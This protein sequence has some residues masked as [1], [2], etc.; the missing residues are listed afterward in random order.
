MKVKIN[1]IL[2]NDRIRKDL[3][4]LTELAQDIKSNGLINPPVVTPGMEL[5]AGERRL[6]ALKLNGESEVDVLVMEIRDAEHMLNLEISENETRKDF[7][8]SERIE[9][10]R[11][12]ERIESLKALQRKKKHTQ[13][14]AEGETREIVAKAIGVS[15]DTLAKEKAIVDNKDLLDPA[16][17]ADWD[18]GKLSTNKL[19]QQVRHE[20]D[21][22]NA[23]LAIAQNEI[24]ALKNRPAKEVIKEVV[25]EVVPEDYE[26]LKSDLE[27]AQREA[28][29]N[30]A[31]RKEY[32]D[33][34]RAAESRVK[35]LENRES[36][37]SRVERLKS[38]A[39][40]FTTRVYDF[41]QSIGGMAW[42]FSS[43]EDIDEPKVKDNFIKAVN[44]LNGFSQ[45]MLANVGGDV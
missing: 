34:M 15:H 4:D 7:S 5:I 2:I 3:G 45:Q 22:K 16:D 26:S 9:Y 33:R 28:Q 30:S 19:F 6:A 11:R 23:D 21:K 39:S 27:S 8:K 18:E 1:D 20:L 41:I 13:N 43:Y 40:I 10:A 24:N 42:V 25:K 36:E 35:E 29:R 44:D 37:F 12:L 38:E 17:F 14:S 32:L 31:E